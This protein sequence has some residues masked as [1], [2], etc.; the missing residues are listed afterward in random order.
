MAPCAGWFSNT[1]GYGIVYGGADVLTQAESSFVIATANIAMGTPR[2]I[3]WHL[4]NA[5][6]GGATFEEIQAVRKIAIEVAFKS[7]VTWNEE[8]PDVT[9]V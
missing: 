3:A 7:G 1:V 2:Q 8:I 4:K 9:E 5:M 6:N